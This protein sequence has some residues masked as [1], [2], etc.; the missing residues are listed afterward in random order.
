M[1]V[2]SHVSN[3]LMS[4]IKSKAPGKS[5]KLRKHREFKNSVINRDNKSGKNHISKMCKCGP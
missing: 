5:G 3:V 2:M 1:S 4:V